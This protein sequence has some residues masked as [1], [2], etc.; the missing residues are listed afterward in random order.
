MGVWAQDR[1]GSECRPVMV[2]IG[3]ETSLHV[4]TGRL[5]RGLALQENLE[6]QQKNGHVKKPYSRVVVY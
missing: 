1:G 6:L 3:A 4:K 2:R 5:P